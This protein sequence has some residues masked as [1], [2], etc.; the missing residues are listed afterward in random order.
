VFSKKV[1]FDTTDFK[2]VLDEMNNL[3]LEPLKILKYT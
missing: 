2:L 3:L 1:N